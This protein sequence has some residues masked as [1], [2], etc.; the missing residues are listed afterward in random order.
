LKQDWDRRSSFHCIAWKLTGGYST[1]TISSTRNSSQKLVPWL[2]SFS[3]HRNE[4]DVIRKRRREYLECFVQRYQELKTLASWKTRKLRHPEYKLLVAFG[5][6]LRYNHVKKPKA[7]IVSVMLF[8]V[9]SV[10]SHLS[11]ENEDIHGR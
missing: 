10:D 9:T 2:R 8:V 11:G 6:A 5:V 1:S 3:A 7:A 4:N